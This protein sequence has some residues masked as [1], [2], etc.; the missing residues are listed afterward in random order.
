MVALYD[1]LVEL[2]GSPVVALNRAVAVGMAFGPEAALELVNELTGEPALRSYH[3]LPSVRA[4]LL[5]K[6]GRRDEARVELERAAALAQNERE[7]ELLLRRARD[8]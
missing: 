4:D 3:L 7:R 2:T 6:L 1:A 5:I 8:Q